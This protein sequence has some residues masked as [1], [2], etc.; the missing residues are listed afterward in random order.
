MWKKCRR[1]GTSQLI[2]H[3]TH[4]MLSGYRWKYTEAKCA[5]ARRGNAEEWY[6]ADGAP[7]DNTVA[8]TLNIGALCR[9][10]FLHKNKLAL[11]H[12]PN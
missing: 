8:S 3:K 2:K 11:E 1:G 5:N 7:L 6:T 12:G 9:I 4:Q 10:I